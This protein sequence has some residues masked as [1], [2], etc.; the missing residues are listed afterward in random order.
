[1][2]ITILNRNCEIA[3]KVHNSQI[4]T[5]ISTKIKQTFNK[6][7]ENAANVLIYRITGVRSS[8]FPPANFLSGE[9]GAQQKQRQRVHPSSKQS[10]ML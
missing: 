6:I 2:L 8:L 7:K 5:H 1:M 10:E 3:E 9:T 4:R